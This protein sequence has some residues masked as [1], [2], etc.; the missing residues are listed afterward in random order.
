MT[1]RQKAKEEKKLKWHFSMLFIFIY[2]T[3][4]RMSGTAMDG[5][6][7]GVHLLKNK[8]CK[9]LRNILWISFQE[10]KDKCLNKVDK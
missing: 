9:K 7:H 3:L 2:F 8:N 6:T 5:L 10:S 4:R 1:E